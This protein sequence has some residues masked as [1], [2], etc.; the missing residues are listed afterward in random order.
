MGLIRL[1]LAI[2][3]VLVHS[4]IIN[5]WHS[6]PIV[7]GELAVESFFM[8]SGFYMAMVLTENYYSDDRPTSRA[9]GAFLLSRILR[10]YPTYLIV[11]LSAI[12][13]LLFTQHA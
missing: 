4:P 11:L 12:L 8:I 3:V 7:G 6:I 2:S 1:L 13:F 9:Y 10:I 5:E